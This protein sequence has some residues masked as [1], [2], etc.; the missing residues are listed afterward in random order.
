MSPV[1]ETQAAL[2]GLD[3]GTS[4][5]R[6]YRIAADGT[7]LER[8]AAPAGILAVAG[9]DFAGELAR[10]IGDWLA[11][12]PDLPLL[13]SGMIGSRQGWIEVP[14]APCPA[15]AGE[16]VARLVEHRMA[17]GRRLWFVPGLCREGGDGVPDVMRG[18]ET[19][20]LGVDGDAV[21]QLVVLPG[22][23]SKWALVEAGRVVWFATFMTGELFAVLRQHS[24]L[25]RLMAG[26]GDDEAAFARGLA[27]GLSGDR[28]QGGLLHRLFSVRTLGLFDRLPATGLADHLS[29]LLIG[30][31]VREALGC[32]GHRAEGEVVIV[33]EAKL[34]ER[35]RTA[36]GQAGLAA[37]PFAGEA[38]ALGQLAIARAAGLVR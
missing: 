17:S 6:A 2:L 12:A 23:H 10:Q 35:Y 33:G 20:I 28:A 9:G 16:L 8:R 14:Y 24:I 18:E 3:W 5:L 11:A 34:A 13:A 15:G 19:Q 4:A 31:E 36:L 29:G 21:A 32:V 30:E 38:A 27:A 26:D 22:T 25:G 1:A 7:I 37:R